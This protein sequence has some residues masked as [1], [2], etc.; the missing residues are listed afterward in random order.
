MKYH[1]K[2]F[3][4]YTNDS[5]TKIAQWLNT[6]PPGDILSI[7]PVTID[8]AG[9]ESGNGVLIVFRTT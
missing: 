7:T 5:G 3:E 6:L 1:V 2:T 9:G 4:L 8:Y